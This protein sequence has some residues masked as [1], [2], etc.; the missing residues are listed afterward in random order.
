MNPR[1][2]AI[3]LFTLLVASAAHAQFMERQCLPQETE[4]T[5]AFDSAGNPIQ[6]GSMLAFACGDLGR[7]VDV[8]PC[9]TV[10]QRGDPV[11]GVIVSCSSCPAQEPLVT[12][13]GPVCPDGYGPVESVEDPSCGDFGLTICALE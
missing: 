4:C 2:I 9:G 5:V 6:A 12:V 13:C 1:W 8:E 11:Q 3:V 10:D 7:P